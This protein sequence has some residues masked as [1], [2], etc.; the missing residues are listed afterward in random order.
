[1][2][3]LV[4]EL[5]RDAPKLHDEGR[6]ART[7]A[8]TASTPPTCGH[9]LA[10][11]FRRSVSS[12]FTTENSHTRDRMLFLSDSR[13]PASHVASIKHNDA[14]AASTGRQKHLYSTQTRP[15]HLP[16]QTT[17]RGAPRVTDQ[18][19]LVPRLEAAAAANAKWLKCIEFDVRQPQAARRRCVCA[20]LSSN[21]CKLS[22][23]GKHAYRTRSKQHMKH[24]EMG[25]EQ[26]K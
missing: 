20:S 11:A 15:F 24:A 3:H 13:T 16:L 6:R 2:I 10:E 25:N 12:R 9:A 26:Q 7:L 1:M 17:V 21:I 5:V 8:T 4:V 22:R 19:L 18:V 23:D 14:L